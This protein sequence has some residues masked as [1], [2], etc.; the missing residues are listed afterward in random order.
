MSEKIRIRRTKEEIVA[1]IDSKIAY[2][3]DCIA[4]LE[5]QKEGK[6]NPIPRQKKTTMKDISA[7][8]KAK[9]IST[10]ELMKLVEEAEN[11]N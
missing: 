6:L 9:G 2:H 10:D 3:K 8:M 11:N 7:L 4:K 5:A 1:S